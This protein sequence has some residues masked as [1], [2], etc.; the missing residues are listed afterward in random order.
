M[1]S[2]FR[3]RHCLTVA[4]SALIAALATACGPQADGTTGG[5]ELAGSGNVGGT[6]VIASP[7]G[8]NTLMPPTV[9][10]IQGKQLTDLIYERL[11]DVGPAINTFGDKGFE[12]RLA[13]SWDWSADSMAI[14]FHLDPRARWHDGKPVQAGDVRYTFRVNSDSAQSSDA[15]YLSK[16]DSV[17]VPDSLTVTFW[18][19]ARYPEQFYDAAGR[20]SILPAHLLADV[21]A[22]GLNRAPEATAPVGSGPFRF[23][24]LQPGA[25]IELAADT[26]YHLGRPLLDRILMT[27]APNPI[28]AATQLFNGEAD[29]YEAMMPQQMGEFATHPE[30]VAHIEPSLTYNFLQFNLRDPRHPDR[31]HPLLS[32][33][34]LRRALSMLIDREAIVKSA[35]DSLA[36]V[37]LG[38]FPRSL[39]TADTLVRQLPHDPSRGGAI[40]DSLGWRDSNGDGIRDRDGQRL[41]FAV[42]VPT[43]SAFRQRIAVLLQDQFAR[44]GVGLTVERLEFN[45]FLERLGRRAFDTN[46]GS[47]VLTDGSPAGSRATW[48]SG[49]NQNFGSYGNPL[50]DAQLDSALATFDAADRRSHFSRAYQLIVDDAP[51]IWLYEPRNVIGIHRRFVMPPLRTAGWWLDLPR[52]SVRTG[53][54]IARDRGAAS[55]PAAPVA[56]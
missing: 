5:R 26:G 9:T 32:D 15:V 36:V 31:P 18:F 24:R 2:R 41:E 8:P 54:Q 7:T 42:T 1:T 23:V 38:P 30:V 34:E 56:P 39:P 45:T 12:P 51:A 46:L 21:P 16:V 44:N 47:W 13:T 27:V 11:A 33:R 25:L 28:A 22:G 14:T 37:G 10:S 6:L 53:E 19:A 49:G 35:W 40:L 17:S 50:V 55:A 3:H 20:L 4:T 29:L 43:S 52:W 48:G